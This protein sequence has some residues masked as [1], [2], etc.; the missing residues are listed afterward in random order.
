MRPAPGATRT[1]LDET[2]FFQALPGA[3]L[4]RLA[5]AA[6]RVA[7]APG[8]VL[9]RAGRRSS[10]LYALVWGAV[11]VGEM[12]TGAEAA[13]GP[14]A[15]FGAGPVTG[16]VEAIDVEA[17][18]ESEVL[19]WSGDALGSL[20][21]AEPALRE[22]LATRL[23]LRR[24][25]REIEELLHQSYLFRDTSPILLRRLIEL[26][27][28]ARCAPGER[29]C[30]QGDPGDTLFVIVRGYVCIE[31]EN[32]GCARRVAVLSR[33]D[34]VGE[35][36]LVSGVPRTA[37]AVVTGD[38]E[39]LIVGRRAFDALA[40]QSRA[41]SRR[42][43]AVAGE[44][45][46]LGRAEGRPPHLVW[47]SNM[48]TH[49]AEGLALLTAQAMRAHLGAEA[50]LLVLGA[51]GSSTTATTEG[52]VRRMEVPLDAAL[53]A[54]GRERSRYVLCYAAPDVAR[55]AYQA[56]GARLTTELRLLDRG[57]APLHRAE[58]FVHDVWVGAG[59]TQRA[60]GDLR[61]PLDRRMDLTT[62]DFERVSP[63][64]AAALGRIARALAHRRVGVALSGGGAWGYAHCVFLRRLLEAGIPIDVVAGS[65][66]GAVVGA[67]Y[68]SHG[69]AGLDQLEGIYRKAGV[70]AA[71][72]VVSSWAVERAIEHWCGNRELA[73]LD[74]PFLP[75]AVDVNTCRE[76][77]FRSG[78]L[79]TGVRASCA[80]PGV[81][82]PALR[83]GRRYVDGAITDNVP[84]SVLR[85]E[86]ADFVIA[87]AI[88]P[89]PPPRA[90]ERY[91]TWLGRAWAE[92][93]PVGRARDLMRS[94]LLLGHSVSRD[95]ASR[96]DVVFSPDLTPFVLHEW[97]KAP[98]IMEV[99][100]RQVVD[101]VATAV[102]LYAAL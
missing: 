84:V 66:F 67:M 79:A 92:L 14:G 38:A 47:V 50:S 77:A 31:R 97:G 96:A 76:T 17:L 4:E 12:E 42:A 90:P 93:S 51:P 41:F 74:P 101:A 16:D 43:H 35:V 24:R 13:E 1:E 29:L 7:V 87:S 3:W 34:T 65:S 58:R 26:S 68:A 23:S 36:A 81:Y 20:F 8:T 73:E 30:R 60:A 56:L 10:G 15:V 54:V 2:T 25:R 63:P 100:E 5:A 28:L 6:E 57:P 85:D 55:Q 91:E 22:Q 94:V 46:E 86:G 44:R 69:L 59:R 75:V 39:V 61:L 52:G 88:M 71:L 99:A 82:G 53:A 83:D 95:L 70:V 48:S 27:T 19:R 80:F 64:V 9:E 98:Q 49:R 32:G 78:S 62:P 45:V 33:G 40:A 89:A 72:S 102:R 21:D 11:R 37:S 18:E